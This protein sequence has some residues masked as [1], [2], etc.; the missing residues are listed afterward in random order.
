MGIALAFWSSRV[1]SSPKYFLQ[2]LPCCLDGSPDLI[3][4]ILGV[5]LAFL[6]SRIHPSP[7][8]SLP[9]VLMPRG[10][11]IA[12][13]SPRIFSCFRDPPI[14]S[15]S[16]WVPSCP[17]PSPALCIPT[18]LPPC[19][20]SVNCRQSS[21]RLLGFSSRSLAVRDSEKTSM[22]PCCLPQGKTRGNMEEITGPLSARMKTQ[23]DEESRV[24][25]WARCRSLQQTGKMLGVLWCWPSL[26]LH[27]K[28]MNKVSVLRRE[29]KARKI[30][31]TNSVQ[32][33]C[34]HSD[35]CLPCR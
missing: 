34:F 13:M 28:T 22:S 12:S 16:P 14:S 30:G 7:R 1:H 11:L 8:V 9:I 10:P 19:P 24:E 21:P 25:C 15:M 17:P 4:V 35:R 31:Q 2:S 20:P 26:P 33:L 23:G 3:H 5:I 29:A 27:A 32:Q 6:P 18:P